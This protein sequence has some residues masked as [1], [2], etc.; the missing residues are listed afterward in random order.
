M[1]YFGVSNSRQKFRYE[2]TQSTPLDPKRSLGLF[3]SIL[4]TFCTKCFGPEC[5]VSGYR[6]PEKSFATKA[7]HLLLNIQNDA[8]ECSVHFA[9]L[10]QKKLCKDCVPAVNVL[11]QGI[12]LSKKVSLRTHPIYFIRPK[13][14]FAS[15]LEHFADLRHEKW[16]KTYVSGLN[17]LFRGTE[18]SEKSFAMN[19]ANLLH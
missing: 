6:T 15:V 10:R 16:C 17:P 19:S 4:Q 7:P 14:M 12:E 18:L 5:T 2:H 9:N 11:F 13:M 3:Q 1:H 8:L